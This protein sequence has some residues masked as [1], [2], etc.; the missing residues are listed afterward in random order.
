MALP[1]YS[2]MSLAEFVGLFMHIQLE[3]YQRNILE[4]IDKVDRQNRH[5]GYVDPM[6]SGRPN[7]TIMAVGTQTARMI[8]KDVYLIIIDDPLD[9]GRQ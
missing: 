7:T 8:Q 6:F 2:K 1:D 3:P 4:L 9:D 5:M